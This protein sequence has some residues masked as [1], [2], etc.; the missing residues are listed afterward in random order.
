MIRNSKNIIAIFIA[1]ITIS[2]AYGQERNSSNT[3]ILDWSIDPIILK[4]DAGIIKSSRY[5]ESKK[6]GNISFK[7]LELVNFKGFQLFI[8]KKI[9]HDNNSDFLSGGITFSLDC[10]TQVNL[11]KDNIRF[12]DTTKQ[13]ELSKEDQ[14]DYIEGTKLKSDQLYQLHTPNA[15]GWVHTMISFDV[16]GGS[17]TKIANFCLF[18]NKKTKQLCGFGNSQ[19]IPNRKQLGTTKFDYT[20]ILIKILNTAQFLDDK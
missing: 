12:N 15:F 2:V 7:F 10:T 16:M 18:N 8:T 9:P 14:E 1:L 13:W 19:Y 6:C 4:Y 20:P 11:T 5:K 17:Y 3:K